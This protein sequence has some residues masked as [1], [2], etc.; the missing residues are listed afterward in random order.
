MAQQMARPVEKKKP[1][2]TVKLPFQPSNFFP[3]GGR[4]STESGQAHPRACI[5][6][7]H[8]RTG[9][10]CQEYAVR[11]EQRP[12]VSQTLLDGTAKGRVPY[13]DVNEITEAE[14]S[15]HVDIAAAEPQAAIDAFLQM[16]PG[17]FIQRILRPADILTNGSK[18][19]HRLRIELTQKLI[20]RLVM[21]L[22][23]MV[24][25]LL[26]YQSAVSMMPGCRVP[27]CWENVSGIYAGRYRFR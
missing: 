8:A 11:G 12:F 22:H 26:S 19:L 25:P 6:R 15:V 9:T 23:P 21:M 16:R 4:V 20:C 13:Q 24:S 27:Y 2:E 3:D 5:V 7:E 17:V 10:V 14:N 18:L 1:P